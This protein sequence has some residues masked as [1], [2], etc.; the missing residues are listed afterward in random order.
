MIKKYDNLDNNYLQGDG[1]IPVALNNA[2]PLTITEGE[3]RQ[4]LSLKDYTKIAFVAENNTTVDI[5]F[6]SMIGTGDSASTMEIVKDVTASSGYAL[7]LTGAQTIIFGTPTSYVPNLLKKLTVKA[8][9]DTGN[10]NTLSASLVAYKEKNFL[11]KDGNPLLTNYPKITLNDEVLTDAYATYIG[12]VSGTGSAF[13]EGSTTADNPSNMPTG[14]DEVAMILDSSGGVFYVDVISLEEV[15]NSIREIPDGT[16]VYN[17]VADISSDNRIAPSE[18]QV[19]KIQY[20]S[21]VAEYIVAIRLADARDVTT[22]DYI[23]AYDALITY[24]STNSILDDLTVSTAIIGS[25]FRAVV[26]T[27]LLAKAELDEAI[28]DFDARGLTLISNSSAIQISDRGVLLTTDILFTVGV[29]LLDIDNV[30][31]STTSGTLSVVDDNNQILDCTTMVGDSVIVSVTCGG[32]T[33]SITSTKMYATPSKG[34]YLGTLE[35]EPDVNTGADGEP[36]VDGDYF[37]YIGTTDADFTE[38]HIY[39]RV[40][41]SWDDTLENKYIQGELLTDALDIAKDSKTTMYAATAFLDKL[42]ANKV[43]ITKELNVHYEETEGIP[44]QG[45][46]VEADGILKAV[47]AFLVGADIR[48]LITSDP[49]STQKTVDSG[50]SASAVSPTNTLWSEANF[51]ANFPV[52]VSRE[53]QSVTFSYL[54]SSYTKATKVVNQQLIYSESLGPSISVTQWLGTSNQLIKEW[55]V[56]S[57]MPNGDETANYVKIKIDAGNH[58]AGISFINVYRGGSLVLTYSGGSWGGNYS[59]PISSTYLH[60]GDVIKMY[61]NASSFT[62]GLSVTATYTRVQSIGY[63]TGIVALKSDNTTEIL[64]MT[65]TA[66]KYQ[67][68]AFSTSSPAWNVTSIMDRKSGTDVYDAFSSFPLSTYIQTDGTINGDALSGVRVSDNYVQFFLASEGEVLIN[69]FQVGTTIGVYLTLAMSAIATYEQKEAVLTT[70]MYPKIN[71]DY[72]LGQIGVVTPAGLVDRFYRDLYLTGTGHM[73]TINTGQG[74]FEI[75][76]D[77]LTTSDVE[78]ATVNTGFGA[79]E[80]Y[81]VTSEDASVSTYLPSISSRTYTLSSM[82]IGE[83]KRFY[84]NVISRDDNTASI[85]LPSGGVFGSTFSDNYLSGGSIVYEQTTH[86]YESTNVAGIVWRIS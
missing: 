20:D 47:G 52:D 59:I 80:V 61:W 46:K 38:N 75:G 19:F 34:E 39:A 24:V 32:Y 48:G 53:L 40:G 73:A 8:R 36:L 9:R 26:A 14:T 15:P 76:Q 31:W 16:G 5:D 41:E 82:V 3:I 56:P 1:S 84:G 35:E 51:Y 7:K 27:Y 21:I 79:N 45:M 70:N 23:T 37:L 10:V 13:V 85:T 17:M 81:R 74:N 22:T 18:K 55:T 86:S 77:V 64:P 43:Y 4:S 25:A 2:I 44:S 63:Y 54:S 50:L 6:L 83:T 68:Y 29:K 60:P 62:F 42:Y 33:S 65:N 69:K 78:F 58:L 66:T 72:D 11:N 71:G 67:N 12:F 49:L 57:G 30:V 28:S